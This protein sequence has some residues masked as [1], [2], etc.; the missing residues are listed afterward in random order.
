MHLGFKQ[1]RLKSAR[2]SM[3]SMACLS[4]VFVVIIE[5]QLKDK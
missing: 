4:L 3:A 1:K 2:A 5:A